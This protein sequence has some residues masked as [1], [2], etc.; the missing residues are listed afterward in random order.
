MRMI[1]LVGLLVALVVV[2]LLARKQLGGV[3]APVLPTGSTATGDA[4]AQSRQIQQQFKQSLDAAVQA[5][6]VPD[7]N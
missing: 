7:D 5:R 3:A 4:R 6:P 1:G 2:G